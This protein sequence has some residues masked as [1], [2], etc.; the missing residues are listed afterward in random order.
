[1][2]DLVLR[3]YQQ[4]NV[5]FFLKNG[6]IYLTDDTGLGKTVT[7]FA[8]HRAIGG[9]CG[10]YVAPKFLLE[11]IAYKNEMHFRDE[12]FIYTGSIKQRRELWEIYKQDVKEYKYLITNYAM[13]KEIKA[14][15]IRDNFFPW[16]IALFD[17]IH[18]GQ[19]GL[20]SF[21]TRKKKSKHFEQAEWFCK[22]VP[23]LILATATPMRQNIGDF[24]APL[25]LINPK[26]FKGYYPFI[27]KYGIVS[28]GAFGI[29][30]ERRANDVVKFRSMLSHYM[31]RH[32]F[33]EVSDQLLP[34][35]IDVIPLAMSDNQKKYYKQLEED[36]WIIVDD[37]IEAIAST[38]LT[39]MLYQRQLL[40]CPRTFG[41]NDNGTAI[42]YIVNEIKS[43]S[44]DATVA[45]FVPFRKTAKVLK[46][47]LGDN[48]VMIGMGGDKLGEKSAKF[49]A[50][51]RKKKIWIG[52]IQSAMG[53]DLIGI[54]N[55]YF[56][57]AHDS[58]IMNHQAEGRALAMRQTRPIH[59][60]YLLYK[61]TL[62][63][64]LLLRLKGKQ[65]AIDWTTLPESL[66][67]KK[68]NKI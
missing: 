63:Q 59:I 8:A 60:K 49:N 14:N 39:K 33:S 65:D 29:E 50:S 24:F 30:I 35:T 3:P 26:F 1:M 48:N 43:L 44:D 62:H 17:E 11:D 67:Q 5:D 57:G 45:I 34:V 66:F 22:K 13:L 7:M 42:D 38:G 12:V 4:D 55:M 21:K 27:Y 37:E 31:V 68:F 19:S 40:N 36:R 28:N 20:M 52:T 25:H 16:D 51:D 61:G 10:L 18:D 47:A 23:H 46:E 56:I 2:G 6:R 9:K 15:C 54:S 58:P 41:I 64:E 53:Y 32:L